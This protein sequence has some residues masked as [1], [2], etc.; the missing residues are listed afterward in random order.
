M[1]KKYHG[2]VYYVEL[3]SSME[4]TVAENYLASCEVLWDEEF[5][6]EKYKKHMVLYSKS[7]VE[8]FRGDKY[9]AWEKLK[10]LLANT[11]SIQPYLTKWR[12]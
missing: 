2:K 3:T 7:P 4:L 1:I 6:T 8:A 5:Y 11:R 9:S 12:V 10:V